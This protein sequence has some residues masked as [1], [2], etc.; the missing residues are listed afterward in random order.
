MKRK[1]FRAKMWAVLYDDDDYFTLC[2]CR[3]VARWI[4]LAEKDAVV[5]PVEVRETT[6]ARR[7][8]K[9]HKI[10]QGLREA[11]EHA[12]RLPTKRTE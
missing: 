7:K 12:K 4:K 11:V 5:V 1:P 8:R 9:P 10:I 3:Y 6:P 2:R